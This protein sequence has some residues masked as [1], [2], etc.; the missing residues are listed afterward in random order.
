M[1]NILPLL[2][3][4]TLAFDIWVLFSQY[5]F[6]VCFMLFSLWVIR[7][8]VWIAL[9]GYCT[10]KLWLTDNSRKSM[11]QVFGWC[12]GST[13][14][15]NLENIHHC[16][17]WDWEWQTLE[18]PLWKKVPY[19][20][21]GWHFS[22]SEMKLRASA[23]NSIW[24]TDHC[25]YQSSIF[26]VLCLVSF[27]WSMANGEQL[28]TCD[29]W[30]FHIILLIMYIDSP[31]GCCLVYSLPVM[32][33]CPLLHWWMYPNLNLCTATSIWLMQDTWI[34]HLGPALSVA[35][36]L[37]LCQISVLS[38]LY[39]CLCFLSLQNLT[40]SPTNFDSAHLILHALGLAWVYNCSLF[41]TDSK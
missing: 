12:V 2:F 9:K 7:L 17:S 23:H 21:A 41:T 13:E 4:V 35:S 19:L 6:H 40:S 31:G 29:G 38:L 3:C 24:N 14:W 33:L 22:T 34:N 5:N 20:S 1:T 36:H 10:N 27:R 32:H 37:S 15:T 39:P 16:C 30:L 28:W 26:T 11:L 25:K 18:W 8:T